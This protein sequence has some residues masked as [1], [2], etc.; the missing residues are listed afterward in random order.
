MTRGFSPCQVSK[1]FKHLPSVEKSTFLY[2]IVVVPYVLP[3]RPA[4]VLA[5]V[6]CLSFNPSPPPPLSTGLLQT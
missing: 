4:V 6:C 1:V 5:L 3:S 2:V